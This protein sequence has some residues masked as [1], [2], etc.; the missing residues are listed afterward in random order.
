LKKIGTMELNIE[1]W[2]LQQANTSTNKCNKQT[3]TH[4][5]THTHTYKFL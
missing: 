1:Y 2:L 4:T 3:H 5:H